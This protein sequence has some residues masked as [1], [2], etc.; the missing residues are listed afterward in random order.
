MK[1]FLNRPTPIY[2]ESLR[3]YLNRLATS[4]YV[5]IN[6]LLK[7]FNL[8]LEE[9]LTPNYLANH[10]EEYAPKI[11]SIEPLVNLQPGSLIKKV[12]TP[13]LNGCV[14][15][16]GLTMKRHHI[17]NSS[18][19]CHHCLT[20]NPIE[21]NVWFLRCY[22]IC[23]VH[24][25]AIIPID[26]FYTNSCKIFANRIEDA[27]SNQDIEAKEHSLL[28]EQL[29]KISNS[30]FTLKSSSSYIPVSRRL[31]IATLD[32]ITQQDFFCC[33]SS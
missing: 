19:V 25:E 3:S 10:Y 18:A 2:S 5:S 30:F 4:N 24:N 29:A 8:P 22:N 31:P 28:N 7:S 16:Y 6:T 23:P 27:F 12:P 14:T 11:V 9:Q 17:R 33:L 21:K 15:W 13:S 32:S 1:K 20:N 26:D